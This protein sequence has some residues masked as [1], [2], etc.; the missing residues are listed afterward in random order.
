MPYLLH[1]LTDKYIRLL[2]LTSK[3]EKSIKHGILIHKPNIKVTVCNTLLK[4]SFSEILI[5]TIDNIM[6]NTKIYLTIY[7][8][9]SFINQQ[10]TCNTSY[11]FPYHLFHTLNILIHPFSFIN[12]NMRRMMNWHIIYSVVLF[13]L[14]IKIIPFLKIKP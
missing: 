2:S 5:K 3:C 14:K 13:V 4:N 9:H 7:I 1:N 11:Q 12:T 8:H 6:N 10:I